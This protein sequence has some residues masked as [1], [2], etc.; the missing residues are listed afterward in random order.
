MIT[1]LELL[2]SYHAPADAAACWIYLF[3]YFIV[4][5]SSFGFDPVAETFAPKTVL[6]SHSSSVSVSNI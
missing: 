6:V 4:V 1:S 2:T 5:F 3:I